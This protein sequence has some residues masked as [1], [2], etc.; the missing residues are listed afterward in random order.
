MIYTFYKG[1]ITLYFNVRAHL[2]KLIYIFKTVIED[3][4]CYDTVALCNCQ[5]NADLRLHICRE[6]RIRQCLDLRTFQSSGSNHTYCIIRLFNLTS[7]LDQLGCRGFQMLGNDIL[8][9]YITLGNRC[10][11]HK[12]TCFDLIRDN[13][14]FCGMKLRN[15]GNSHYVCTRS[16]D[17][18]THRVQEIRYIYYMWLLGC[19]L[20][21]SLALCQHRSQHNINRSTYRY[22][23]QINMCTC[24]LLGICNDQSML[25][26]HLCAQSL[27][28]LNMQVNLTAADI[29]SARK[30][31][32]CMFV[33]AK[34]SP[35]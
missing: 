18:S 11:K 15:T 27:K 26:L 19:I 34:Q 30:C 22:R 35:Q 20:D 14:I 33:F 9:C 29:A 3:A 2:G 24:K 7:H 4:L 17:I 16:L 28:A 25:N 23:I 32:F 21:Y 6:S 12:C 31:Y 10:S 13:G 1:S 8:Y 5:C